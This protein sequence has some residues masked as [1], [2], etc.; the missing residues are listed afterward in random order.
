M[1]NPFKYLSGGG[2]H[3]YH[4]GIAG[5]YSGF[6]DR[7]ISRDRPGT[8]YDPNYRMP[9]GSPSDLKWQSPKMDNTQQTTSSTNPVGST[10]IT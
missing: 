10:S 3:D 6:G 7:N 9:F 8:D 2:P 1:A 4:E 5:T